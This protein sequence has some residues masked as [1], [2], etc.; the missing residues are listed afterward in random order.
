[1]KNTIDLVV[2]FNTQTD[3]SLA[4]DFFKHESNFYAYKSNHEF[5]SLFFEVNDEQEA[6]DLEMMI[7]SELNEMRFRNFYFSLEN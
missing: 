3:F 1:M 7:E 4:L 2:N 6:N 5:R